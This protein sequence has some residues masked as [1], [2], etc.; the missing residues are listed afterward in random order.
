MAQDQTDKN[1]DAYFRSTKP[2]P[3]LA[4]KVGDE[5]AYARYFLKQ[6]RVGAT[7]AMWHAR[8]KVTSTDHPF[9]SIVYVLWA[10]ETEA[11]PIHTSCLAV[12]GPNLRFCE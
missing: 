12:P 6:L 4:V 9:K 1:L 8:G 11:K 2:N 3:P 5:V 7:D 10:G